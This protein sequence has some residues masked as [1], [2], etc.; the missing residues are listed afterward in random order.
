MAPGTLPVRIVS[1]AFSIQIDRSFPLH[2]IPV[3]RL[4]YYVLLLL[5]LLLP[6]VVVSPGK[7]KYR[8]GTD[9][10]AYLYMSVHVCSCI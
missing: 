2:G 7:K 5:L 8:R 6:G 4:T 10:N 3:P 9:V 1:V